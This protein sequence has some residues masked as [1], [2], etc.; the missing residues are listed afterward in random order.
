MN[1]RLNELSQLLLCSFDEARAWVRTLERFEPVTRDGRGARLVT[2]AQ[3][4]RIAV[5]RF[6]AANR[7]I[8]RG[9]ALN[10]V[11]KL[12]ATHSAIQWLET[13]REVLGVT[14]L[15]ARVARFEQTH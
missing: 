5:A 10:F 2:S 6:V 3:L 8:S 12:D 9:A 15:E 13:S 7:P 11:L 4:E 1:Y 14:A